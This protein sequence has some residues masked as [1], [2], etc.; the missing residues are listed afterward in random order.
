MIVFEREESIFFKFYWRLPIESTDSLGSAAGWSVARLGLGLSLGR[1]RGL[2]RVFVLANVQLTDKQPKRVNL[3]RK[4][5]GI[6]WD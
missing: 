6:A 4:L 2:R 3:T 1:E 5:L